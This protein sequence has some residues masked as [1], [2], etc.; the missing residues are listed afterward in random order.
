MFHVMDEQAKQ[1]ERNS[2]GVE[3]FENK[4]ALIGSPIMDSPAMVAVPLPMCKSRSGS[5][6]LQGTSLDH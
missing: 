2:P 5:V 6:A 4:E 1:I 3:K